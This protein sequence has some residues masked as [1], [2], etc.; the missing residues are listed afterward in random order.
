MSINLNPQKGFRDLY[1]EDKAYQDYLFA[2]LQ[3]LAKTN[4]FL[5]YDGP[6]I[7]DMNIYLN[8]SSEE[9]IKRQ[10]F[11]IQTKDEAKNLILRPEMTPSLARMIARKAGELNFPIKLFNLG[12]RFRYEA[13]QKGR[14]REFYQA[15]FDLLGEN[16]LLADAEII[17]TA[18]NLFI[19]L[20]ATEND[21][22]LYLNSRSMMENKIAAFGIEKNKIKQLLSIIDRQDKLSP[23]EFSQ[24]LADLPLAT[25]QV[26]QLLEFLQQPIAYQ[27]DPYF[28]GL[29]QLLE[30]YQI[31][32]Y[33]QISPQIVRGLDYYTGL[34]FEVKE[35]GG[36]TRSLLGGGR[37][38]NLVASYNP[39]TVIP[40][41]GFATS[42]VVLLE[43]M[44]SKKL[45]P[46]KQIAPAQILVT[47][48]NEKLTDNSVALTRQLR[49][50]G[51]SVEIYPGT[52]KKLDKQ[53]KWA[54]KNNI[55]YVII[56]GP[57]EAENNTFLLKNMRNG[58]QVLI[59]DQQQL[60]EFI[61]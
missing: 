40:G 12:L 33:C 50:Q 48:F 21:F 5:A 41:V 32:Q 38:D 11:Q 51:W 56:L 1:P 24:L 2:L 55:T 22:T 44:K 27:E 54:D 29:F 60:A 34:V 35:K 14:E 39:K 16:S 20:G 42:D 17:N 43:F 6:L 30:A 4:G 37:Y 47:V 59:N 26:E 49:S 3:Q 9:L 57:E 53:L 58:E 19:T 31:R 7:E 25:Q 52:Q 45:L 18:V 8:K 23:K 61:K 46:P 15:D 36:L 28:N 10:T 13:P